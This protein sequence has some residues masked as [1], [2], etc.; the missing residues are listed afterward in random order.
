[1]SFSL[2]SQPLLAVLCIWIR[3]TP[4]GM[5][6]SDPVTLRQQWEAGSATKFQRIELKFSR[7]IGI[8]KAL[9]SH[10]VKFYI[11]KIGKRENVSSALRLLG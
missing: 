11:K 6:T 9:S 7:C 8:M 10:H 1:M 3:L 2:E 5:E 4:S